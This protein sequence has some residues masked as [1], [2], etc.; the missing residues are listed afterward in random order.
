MSEGVNQAIEVVKA[1]AESTALATAAHKTYPDLLQP[2]V[3][4]VGQSLET[5]TGIVNSALRPVK[6]AMLAWNIAW[7]NADRWLNHKFANTPP[8]K[9]AAPPANIAAPALLQLALVHGDEQMNELRNM[10]LELLA[11][12]MH[13]DVASLAHP[14]FVE[15]IKQMTPHEARYVGVI[16]RHLVN[17]VAFGRILFPLLTWKLHFKESGGSV[18]LFELFDFGNDGCDH[19]PL[20][21]LDNLQ[22]LGIVDRRD[23]MVIAAPA[24][25]EKLLSDNANEIAERLRG[26][27]FTEADDHQIKCDRGLL[28][29]TG[30]GQQFVRVCTGISVD[31]ATPTKGGT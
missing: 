25:Y 4:Q 14:A 29:L 30:F 5:V 7:D 28:E 3:K 27:G 17:K 18:P 24:R 16:G 9:I 2:A 10:Y 6:T 26:Y 22:R 12:S 13:V 21:L 31:G 19:V 20:A 23:D 8:E 11:G 15:V 1:V